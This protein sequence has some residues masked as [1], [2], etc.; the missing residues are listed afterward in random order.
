MKKFLSIALALTL[1]LV[2]L[3]ALAE[4][5]TILCG[6]NPEFQ[7]FESLDDAGN[8]IGFDADLAAELS[9][10]IG[11]TIVFESTEFNSIVPSIVSGKYLIGIS[12]F[13]INEE[14]LMNVDF[15][16]PY[17]TDTQ[18]CIVKDGSGIVDAETLKGKK[19]GSQ[20]GTTGVEAA[21]GYTS[22]VYLYPNI[23]SAFLDMQ[24]GKLDAVIT[25]LPVAN[26]VMN[27]L[28]D[29]SLVV[30]SS[31]DFGVE[32]YAVAI[33]K[34]QDELKAQINASIARMQNDGTIDAL[35]EKWIIGDAE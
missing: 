20:T 11:K 10:D 7:P 27:Q 14:R 25:D 34:G 18:C 5:N 24:G 2:S 31:I 28:N 23:L 8:V 26:T 22:D 19:I 3:S 6:C 17:L 32:Y 9:K 21:E 33:A 4:D 16:D 1:V 13:Y 30:V 35:V 15:S 29:P 12:G